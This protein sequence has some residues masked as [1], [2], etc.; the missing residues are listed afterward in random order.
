MIQF[1]DKTESQ[2]L[3]VRDSWCPGVEDSLSGHSVMLEAARAISQTIEQTEIIP[4][5]D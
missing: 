5:V 1:S 2:L 3:L 4:E